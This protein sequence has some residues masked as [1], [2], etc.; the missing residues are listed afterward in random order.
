MGGIP[1]LP[2]T[3]AEGPATTTAN[4][5]AASRAP[6]IKAQAA[7]ASRG[8]GAGGCAATMQ[9][10]GGGGWMGGE[11]ETVGNRSGLPVKLDR[12]GL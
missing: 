1:A 9:G 4:G 12:P 5:V 3:V 11:S 7:E 6:V 2:F 10:E 8:G